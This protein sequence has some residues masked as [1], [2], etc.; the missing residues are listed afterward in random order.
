M[1]RRTSPDRSSQSSFSSRRF[2]SFRSRTRSDITEASVTVVS[3]P[4]RVKEVRESD[5]VT[6]T[7]TATTTTTAAESSDATQT[8]REGSTA[9]DLWSVSAPPKVTT[10]NNSVLK[11]DT[12]DKDKRN[13]PDE[14]YPPSSDTQIE[15]VFFE[16]FEGP[17]SSE[18]SQPLKILTFEAQND[19]GTGTMDQYFD[20]A[21]DVSMLTLSVSI[22]IGALCLGNAGSQS[23]ILTGLYCSRL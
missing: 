17:I 16:N 12:K 20:D 8:W 6:T 2:R 14:D 23:A 21:A 19:T 7:A 4:P 15:W 3:A 22:I 13:S 5:G 18:K 1:T 10:H 9:P 11:S